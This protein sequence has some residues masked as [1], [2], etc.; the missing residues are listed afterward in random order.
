MVDTLKDASPALSDETIDELGYARFTAP[1]GHVEST[2][3]TTTMVAGPTKSPPPVLMP[4]PRPAVHPTL[5]LTHSFANPD[6][7]ATDSQE[8]QQPKLVSPLSKARLMTLPEEEDEYPEQPPSTYRTP[9]LAPPLKSTTPTPSGL[10]VST[11]DKAGSDTIGKESSSGP[12]KGDHQL[13]QHHIMTEPAKS[14][15]TSS[16]EEDVQRH[17]IKQPSTTNDNV[18]PVDQG[19]LNRKPVTT[20]TATTSAPI[21]PSPLVNSTLAS[22]LS[23]SSSSNDS[24]VTTPK[25]SLSTPNHTPDQL[26]QQQPQQHR[27]IRKSLSTEQLLKSN[28]QSNSFISHSQH[29]SVEKLFNGGGGKTSIQQL[30]QEYL[31]RQNGYLRRQLDALLVDNMESQRQHQELIN[32]MKQLEVQLLEKRHTP[33]VSGPPPTLNEYQHHHYY[34]HNVFATVDDDEQEVEQDREGTTRPIHLQ[35]H[36]I[37]VSSPQQQ[38]RQ[39]HV[40]APSLHHFVPIR[41]KPEPR[42]MRPRSRS[43]PKNNAY[44]QHFRHHEEPIYIDDDDD[45]YDGARHPMRYHH[46]Q[47]PGHELD[48]EDDD[49]DDDDDNGKEDD[50]L[51]TR[52]PFMDEDYF[53]PE[54]YY[55]HHM[56]AAP[57]PMIYYPPPPDAYFNDPPY[58]PP[59]HRRKSMTGLRPPRPPPGFMEPHYGKHHKVIQQRIISSQFY[60]IYRT[61]TISAKEW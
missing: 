31:L 4:R 60:F 5:K 42:P 35:R 56:T 44:Q 32:R 8:Q 37:H 43:V 24:N 57:P 29:P 45:E 36:S 59:L 21:V 19:G 33:V 18:Q 23:S 54:D 14:A 1:I 20:T 3:T 58:P 55:P 30:Q 41:Q 28:Q 6:S 39:R 10:V 7:L 46:Y 25:K 13:D 27:H 50:D 61:K 22:Q 2:N 47:P 38:R 52:P 9:P 15:K 51:D 16:K 53:P 48:Q 40:T 26:G 12:I 49:D 17:T 11:M 34:H